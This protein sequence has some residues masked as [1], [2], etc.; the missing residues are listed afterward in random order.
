MELGLKWNE[1]GI[2]IGVGSGVEFGNGHGNEN[3]KENKKAEKSDKNR[4]TGENIKNKLRSLDSSQVEIISDEANL[5]FENSKW[6]KTKE[7]AEYLRA[8]PKQIR[9]W[10]YQGKIKS[11][12]LLGKSLRFKKSDLDL[13]FKGDHSWE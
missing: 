9:K 7:A 4:I 13:L 2:G 1:E 8:H 10:V 5:I 12:K 6:L 3:K 11:Y